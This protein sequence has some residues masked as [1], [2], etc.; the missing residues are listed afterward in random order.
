MD[1][2]NPKVGIGIR[3]V[4]QDKWLSRGDNFL[5]DIKKKADSF[6]YTVVAFI[7]NGNF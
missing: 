7:E 2:D 3:I 6:E 1:L 5:F 4:D